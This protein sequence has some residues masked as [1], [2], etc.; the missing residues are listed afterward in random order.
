VKEGISW[1]ENLVRRTVRG[2][3]PQIFP[4]LNDWMSK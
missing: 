1:R 2:M 3:N 4:G